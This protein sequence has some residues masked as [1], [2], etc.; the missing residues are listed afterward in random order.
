MVYA[1]AGYDDGPAM[2]RRRRKSYG[3]ASLRRR[4]SSGVAIVDRALRW[5]HET[6][7]GLPPPLPLEGHPLTVAGCDTS[8]CSCAERLDEVCP[9]GYDPLLAGVNMC[10]H[11][12]RRVRINV[13]GQQFEIRAG[14]L[15]RHPSTLLGDAARR[16]RYYD[17][18]RDELFFDRH[19]PS[20]EAVFAYYQYGGRLRRP[21][22]VPDDV[23]LAELE[24]YELEHGAVD[25]YRRAEGYTTDEAPLPTNKVLR[26]LWLL[27]EYPETSRAAYVVAVVSV[28]MT[29]VS[30]VLFCI[31][32]LPVYAL[33]HCVKDEV[34]NFLD[35]FF[36]IETVC[37]AWFTIEV[38]VRF[39]ASPS[40]LRFWRDFKNIVDV[41]AI[42][43]YYVTFINHSLLRRQ[44]ALRLLWQR[45]SA[46]RLDYVTLI[47]VVSTMSCL[48]AKSSASLAFLRVIRLVRVLK[49]T[50]H[51]V[52][53]Q[54]LIMTVRAS[55]EE[56][57]LFLVILLVCMVV[58]SSIIYY[59]EFGVEGSQINSIPD[60]FWWAIIT[61][62][63]V[64][65]GDKVPVGYAGKLIGAACAITGVLTL[66]M[67]VPIIT[68][69]FNR[70]YSHKTGRTRHR[71]T[72]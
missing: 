50:K 55:S 67:P 32:T 42:V 43:P 46:L 16:Q 31:E 60:A 18:R 54:V 33:T 26:R 38:A 8:P 34:P 15:S 61:M 13:S 59:A 56:L 19:R 6:V 21:T 52:G 66:S 58:Y 65:Y 23:F 4:R 45:W 14:L 24:F 41:T 44:G 11:C 69:H 29:L 36:V 1:S 39:V 49:L 70:F 35:P 22:N 20:F 2:A 48:S 71:V 28:L 27:F 5:Y 68:G 30:I 10:E 51:S 62:T 40:K 9:C 63:T 64:G 7:R 12:R 37:T 47:N 57:G 72:A 25:D 17:R 53:L 3:G